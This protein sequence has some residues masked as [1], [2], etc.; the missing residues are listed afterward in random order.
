MR[1]MTY[2]NLMKHFTTQQEAAA[3]FGVLQ[4][5]ISKWKRSGIPLDKQIEAE[6]RI[7][8]GLKADRH[9]KAA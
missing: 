5:T 9:W 7:G 3:F 4:G 6:E 1:G 8:A 2:D